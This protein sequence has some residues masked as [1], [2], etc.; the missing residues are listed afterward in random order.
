MLP[1]VAVDGVRLRHGDLA[2]IGA[3][4][5]GLS[6][7]PPASRRGAIDACVFKKR[8]FTDKQPSVEIARRA[9]RILRLV[10]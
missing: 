2:V 6:V 7:L 4:P 10:S 5:H 8:N 1:L 9:P 3:L